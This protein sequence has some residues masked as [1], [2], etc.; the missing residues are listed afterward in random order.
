LPHPT[1]ANFIFWRQ[2]GAASVVE[3]KFEKKSGSPA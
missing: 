1:E 3:L 2:W